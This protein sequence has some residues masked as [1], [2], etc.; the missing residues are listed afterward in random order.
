MAAVKL[1]TK[2]SE[3][4]SPQSV[5]TTRKRLALSA[6]KNMLLRHGFEHVQKPNKDSKNEDTNADLDIDV[7]SDEDK[8][9]THFIHSYPEIQKVLTEKLDL[10]PEDPRVKIPRSSSKGLKAQRIAAAAC[11]I[12]ENLTKERAAASKTRYKTVS[13][14]DTITE[15]QNRKAY[16]DGLS[17]KDEYPDI[18]FSTHPDDET[19][20][21]L[22]DK[23]HPY[24]GTITPRGNAE[25]YLRGVLTTVESR[26]RDFDKKLKNLMEHYE[27]EVKYHK[28]RTLECVHPT[29]GIVFHIDP[30][31]PTN[32]DDEPYFYIDEYISTIRLLDSLFQ[33]E[34]SNLMINLLDMDGPA[35]KEDEKG[36]MAWEFEFTSVLKHSRNNKMPFSVTPKSRIQPEEFLRMIDV[37]VNTDML[38]LE[39]NKRESAFEKFKNIMLTELGLIVKTKKNAPQTLI[40]TNPRRDDDWSIEI[41]NPFTR[42][43]LLKLWEDI[44]SSEGGSDE[45]ARLFNELSE[46]FDQ[47]WAMASLLRNK[48]SDHHTEIA[49]RGRQIEERALQA[50][51][52]FAIDYEYPRDPSR[53]SVGQFIDLH[54]ISPIDKKVLKLK[55]FCAEV[56]PKTRQLSI[57][58]KL[59]DFD[60]ID[61]FVAEA[62][63]LLK[64]HQDRLKAEEENKLPFALAT[65]GLPTQNNTGLLPGLGG[66]PL[67]SASGLKGLGGKPWEPNQG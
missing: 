49:T 15:E 50:K 45:Q 56:D 66:E 65:N 59:S 52:N 18:I 67:S 12:V 46:E 64:E 39:G 1:S 8:E 3:E 7:D 30:F 14:D 53:R 24:V 51:R 55:V 62:N 63:R 57:F 29:Y 4:L 17:L 32:D 5:A 40:I 10:D 25:Y 36:A 23:N 9:Q 27:F 11:I 21:V 44:R 61:A 42:S 20:L 47:T 58:F 41:R 60:R 31:D 35:H 43:P 13:A 38:T 28:D 22:K 26:A 54:L 48:L 34:I 37:M 33:D 19:V 16:M 2:L 6:V